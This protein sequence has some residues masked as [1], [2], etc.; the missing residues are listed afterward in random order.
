MKRIITCS[1]GTW[2]RPNSTDKDKKVR[3]IGKM[4]EKHVTVAERMKDDT[5]Y[6]PGN[7]L[8]E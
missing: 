3:P 2:N 4:E 7:I 1:D 8:A 5:T 6:K